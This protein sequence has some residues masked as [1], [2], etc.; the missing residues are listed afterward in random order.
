MAHVTSFFSKQT[1]GLTGLLDPD[2]GFACKLGD[3][4]LP[5]DA[6]ILSENETERIYSCAGARVTV[7]CE[8]DRAHDA[9]V[10]GLAVTNT[11]AAP[12]R[13][14]DV[15]SLDL[16]LHTNHRDLRVHSF[17]GGVMEIHYPPANFSETEAIVHPSQRYPEDWEPAY[18]ISS[19]N[20]RSSDANLPIAIVEDKEHTGGLYLSIIWSGDWYMSFFKRKNG[21]YHIAGGM[22]FL[23][24]LMEPGETVELPKILI[25]AYAGDFDAGC[26]AVRRYIYDTCIRRFPEDQRIPPVSF[27]HWFTY[28]ANINEELMM[29]LAGGIEGLGLEY[30][31]MDAGWYY[32]ESKDVFDFSMGTGNYTRVDEKKFPRGLKPLYDRVKSGGF[33][34]GLWFEP[35]RAAPN[36]IIARDF[37]EAMLKTDRR[38][39]FIHASHYY[40]VDLGNPKVVEYTKNYLKYYFEELGLR[41]I[42]WDFNIN[43]RHYWAEADRPGRRGEKE[44]A[45]IHALYDL[46]EWVNREYPQVLIE[47]C[48]SGGNRIDLGTMRHSPVFWCSDQAHNSHIDRWQ[49]A[50]GNRILP[51]IILNR[52]LTPLLPQGEDIPDLYFQE[53]FGGS[54]AIN[55]PVHCWTEETRRRC[56][57]HIGVYKKLREFICRDYYQLLPLPAKIEDPGAWEFIDP[58]TQRGFFQIFRAEGE[59]TITVRLK[60]LT[61][62]SYALIDPYTGRRDSN[63][64][65]SLKEGVEFKLPPY[66]S[67]VRLFEAE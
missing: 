3:L 36:S 64:A 47:G 20:G 30:F 38:G 27:D 28:A 45:H 26:N 42:R 16:T 4:S 52:S 56:I 35:E 53:H 57:K 46:L 62:G 9:V 60:G 33:K 63:N 18:R 8:P 2:T 24:L 15:C 22:M 50:A 44:L 31:V 65:A 25:G 43:P 55:D 11:A 17:G 7:T 32:N 61:R 39:D 34:G 59:E 58:E 21:D 54:F 12:L 49:L 29:K 67:A 13:L 19:R 14:H 48:A 23:D 6:T 10:Y 5:K 41:W 1:A 40:L 66:S 37:P 51:G